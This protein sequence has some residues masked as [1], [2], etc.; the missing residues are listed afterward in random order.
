MLGIKSSTCIMVTQ[1]NIAHLRQQCH[2][3]KYVIFQERQLSSGEFCKLCYDTTP[4]K[5]ASANVSFYINNSKMPNF[6]L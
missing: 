4:V 5:S 2:N 1:S 6:E 3:S